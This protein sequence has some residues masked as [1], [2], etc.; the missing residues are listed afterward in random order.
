MRLGPDNA[1]LKPHGRDWITITMNC[2]MKPQ[3]NKAEVLAI[4]KE[5]EINL[6]VS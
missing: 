2:E 5:L 3:M 4:Q 6:A 1:A